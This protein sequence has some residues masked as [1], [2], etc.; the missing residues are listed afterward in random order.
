MH[1]IMLLFKKIK[2]LFYI[3]MKMAAMG[4]KNAFYM[5]YRLIGYILL[6]NK[7]DTILYCLCP[8][9]ILF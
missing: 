7:T 1:I 9:H 8:I 2:K 4:V 6:F 3:I 5:I